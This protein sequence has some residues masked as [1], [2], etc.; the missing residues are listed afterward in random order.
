MSMRIL[1]SC[2]SRSWGGME[3]FAVDSARQLQNENFDVYFFCLKGS[4]INQHLNFIS[5]DRILSI[6]S[7]S[8]FNPLNSYQLRKFINKNKIDIIHTQYSRDLWIIVPALAFLKKHIPLILTKQLG[9]FIIKKDLL[10]RILYKRV[11][12]AVAISTVIKNNLIETTPISEDKIVIIHNA[13]DLN[14]FDRS[15]YDRHQIRKSFSFD[16][17]TFIF[18]NISRLSPGKGQDLVLKSISVIKNK[19]LDTKFVFVGS[20]QEDEK[21]YENQLKDFVER[22]GLNQLV[23]FLG[24]RSDI[25]ELLSMSDAFIFPSHAEAF[26]ISL[27][28]AMAVG[29]PTII[30]KADGVLD[31]IIEN[32]TSLVFE[33]NDHDALAEAILK[34]RFDEKL[35][36][37]LSQSSIERAKNFSFSVYNNKIIRLYKSLLKTSS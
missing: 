4:K 5:R 22:N 2:L 29:L 9:S 6:K 16:S 27:I 25:P 36:E 12:K 1:I 24:F 3:M 33:R 13:I 11:D 32:E 8:Y 20:A 14:K 37:K 26:G 30:C 31:I 10:H 23:T 18:M 28:E 17:N 15:K 7:N 35:R 21:F 19:L 34:I